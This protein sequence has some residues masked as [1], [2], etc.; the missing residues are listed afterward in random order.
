MPKRKSVEANVESAVSN[1]QKKR[2]STKPKTSA[3][4]H[5]RASKKTV[6]SNAVETPAVAVATMAPVPNKPSSE[7]IAKLAYSYW[8]ARGCR[9]GCPN[10]DWFRAERELSAK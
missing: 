1:E 3:A 2:A 9:G 8:E 5:K 4:T 7:D 6:E 10:E